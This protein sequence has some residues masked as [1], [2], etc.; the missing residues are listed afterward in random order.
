MRAAQS[1]PARHHSAFPGPP[2]HT[3]LDS[4][5]CPPG[6]VT[7]AQLSHTD[8]GGPHASVSSERACTLCSSSP[9]TWKQACWAGL[10]CP[11]AVGGQRRGR[12]GVRV[13]PRSH[14]WWGPVGVG[15]M[16]LQPG[17]PDLP[18]LAIPAA[19]AL[20]LLMCLLGWD[21]RYAHL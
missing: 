8:T 6:Y 20:C 19:S 11:C 15:M 7:S 2:S 14:S 9:V 18:L 4:A 16:A 12:E 1:T 5:S 17:H 3:C 10:W 21:G 13:K